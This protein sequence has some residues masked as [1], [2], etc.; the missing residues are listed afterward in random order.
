[1]TLPPCSIS[2]LLSYA[3]LCNSGYYYRSDHSHTTRC[4]SSLCHFI[5]FGC[6]KKV[7]CCLILS[8]HCIYFD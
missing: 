4:F 6:S 3:K 5:R 2:L 1:V 8:V 7:S